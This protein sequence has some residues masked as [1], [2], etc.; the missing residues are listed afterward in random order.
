MKR[1]LA[2]VTLAAFGMVRPAGAG[3]A[4]ALFIAKGCVACHGADGRK[5]MARTPH[6]AGQNAAYLLRQMTEIADGVRS[7]PAAATM[8]PVIGKATPDDRKALADWLAM[9][10][11]AEAVPGDAAKAEQGALLFEDNGCIGCHGAEGAKPLADYPI[12]AGQRKD[13]LAAQIRLIRDD[14][15]STRRAHLMVANVRQ[16]K[17]AEVEQVAE[18]LSQA[19]RN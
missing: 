10:V 11:P 12:L 1:I 2:L 7:T 8:K 18:F 4:G 16:F 15:R 19:K 13:Y 9:Q 5:A 6:L 3:D 14:I 17:E